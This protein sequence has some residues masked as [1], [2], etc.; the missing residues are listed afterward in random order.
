MLTRIS[1]I[2]RYLPSLKEGYFAKGLTTDLQKEL[3]KGTDFKTKPLETLAEIW[4]WLGLIRLV[5]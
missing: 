3:R 4:R 5:R 1:I 2:P